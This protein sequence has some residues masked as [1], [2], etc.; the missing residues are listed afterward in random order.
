MNNFTF[1]EFWHRP[2]DFFWQRPCRAKSADLEH[3]PDFL[4]LFQFLLFS[5]FFVCLTVFVFPRLFTEEVNSGLALT[6][7]CKRNSKSKIIAAGSEVS[8]ARF[9]NR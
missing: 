5:S 8:Q 7:S 2:Y 1:V 6:E 9:V 3:N 4:N